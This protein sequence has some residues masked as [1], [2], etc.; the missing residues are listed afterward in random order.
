MSA[1]GPQ[2]RMT[3]AEFLAWEVQ[4]PE[5]HE[6][7]DGEVFAMSGAEAN[8]VRTAGNVYVALR[9]HL[10]KGPCEVFYGDMKL[11][12]DERIFYPDVF[13]TCSEAD[14]QRRQAMQAPSLIVEVLSPSTAA[15]DRGDKFGLYRRIPSLR[16]YALIDPASR[17][18]DVFRKQPD[19][20]WLLHPFEPD[21]GIELASV[22]LRIEAE[23][24]FARVDPDGEAG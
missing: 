11:Q 19:G 18:C 4:Q 15:H 16:E 23:T 9:Q 14:R 12:V 7:V 8:H 13:V 2:D 20:L 3:L 21:E 5:R 1:D 10:A 6:F 24:L 22:D 17:R